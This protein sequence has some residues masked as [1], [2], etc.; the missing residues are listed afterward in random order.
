M[1]IEL[2]RKVWSFLSKLSPDLKNL[3]IIVLFFIVSVM[4]F[5]GLGKRLVDD[6]AKSTIELRS[7]AENYSKK[8]TPVINE[9]VYHILMSDPDAC[10]VLLLSYHNS[11]SSM[12]GFSYL[13]ITGITEEGRWNIT[14]PY[15]G[16][17]TELSAINYGNELDRIHKL[18][19]LRI[20]NIEDMREDYPKLYFKLKEC[21][22]KSAAFY[23]IQSRNN[24]VGMLVILYKNSK[25]YDLGYYM[26]TIEPCITELYSI[27]NYTK[28]K[29]NMK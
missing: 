7:E 10:N 14:E 27:L 2:L 25:E 21:D 16:N 15:I 1:V 20:D 22:A 5:N 23:P 4:S 19:Y 3:I 11:Q 12:Q 13:W 18:K 28:E 17:W 29:E 24:I 9:N 6:V 8:M 26:E